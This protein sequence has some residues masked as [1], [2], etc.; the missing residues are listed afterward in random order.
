M[1]IRKTTTAAMLGAMMALI[2]MASPALAGPGVDNV[3]WCEGQTNAPTRTPDMLRIAPDGRPRGTRS[4]GVLIIEARNAARAGRDDE[5]IEWAVL[6]QSHNESAANS[7]RA[8]RTAV[9]AY[10]R[11]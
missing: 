4:A 11:G 3:K 8:E 7:I 1:T 2:G 9:L 10:L 6:C 5:A